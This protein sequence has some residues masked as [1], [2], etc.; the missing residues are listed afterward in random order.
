[1]FMLTLNERPTKQRYEAELLFRL[2]VDCLNKHYHKLKDT[3]TEGKEVH[4]YTAE[5]DSE[6][7]LEMLPYF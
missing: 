6:K 7:V 5:Y 1:M 3:R 4:R 2:Y